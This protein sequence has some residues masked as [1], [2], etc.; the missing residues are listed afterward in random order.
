M[1]KKLI[2]NAL[3]CKPGPKMDDVIKHLSALLSEKVNDI[4]EGKGFVTSNPKLAEAYQNFCAAYATATTNSVVDVAGSLSEVRTM[5]SPAEEAKVKVAEVTS[6]LFKKYSNIIA[7][8]ATDSYALLKAQLSVLKLYIEGEISKEAKAVNKTLL[9]EN[10]DTTKALLETLDKEAAGFLSRGV[11]HKQSAGKEEKALKELYTEE[12]N[13]LALKYAKQVRASARINDVLSA[14]KESELVQEDT[15][16]GSTTEEGKKATSY[17]FSQDVY[18]KALAVVQN[19]ISSPVNDASLLS[20]APIGPELFC[21]KHNDLILVSFEDDGKF[22]VE[23]AELSAAFA[24]M[25][26][27]YSS[28]EELKLAAVEAPQGGIFSSI[29]GS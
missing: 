26:A 3:S 13:V 12:S 23:K 7:D 20:T 25:V 2:H 9:N 19:A 22:N 28:D 29:C 11:N 4:Q 18:S 10:L 1:G 24:K 6:P 15:V 27:G 21:T 14:V 16:T 8:Q 17:Q 5:L